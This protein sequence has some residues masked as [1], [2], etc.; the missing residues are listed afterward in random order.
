LNSVYGTVTDVSPPG[1][2][3]RTSRK[4]TTMMTRN[5]SHVRR[6][7]ICAAGGVPCGGVEGAPGLAGGGPELPR[8]RWTSARCLEGVG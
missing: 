6:G 3:N 5:V 7:G 2:R 4:L 8:L 1:K